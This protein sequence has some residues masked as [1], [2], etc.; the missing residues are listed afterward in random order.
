MKSRSLPKKKKSQLIRSLILTLIASL[1][2]CDHITSQ[3]LPRL[4]NSG[5]IELS[6]DMFRVSSLDAVENKFKGSRIALY[7][8]K[9]YL[10]NHYKLMLDSLQL[11]RL[12]EDNINKL[13]IQNYREAI[14]SCMK[15]V[16][17]GS[18]QI[19]VMNEVIKKQDRKIKWNKFRSRLRTIIEASA[20]IFA[21]WF[22]TM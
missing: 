21:A 22:L 12:K 15:G 16:E 20:V 2:I 17:A 14:D 19:K 4:T 1:L 10:E 13:Q 3:E 9:E 18:D 11:I 7:E 5:T 6:Q 8:E